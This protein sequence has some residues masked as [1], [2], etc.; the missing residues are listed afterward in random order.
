MY[1]AGNEKHTTKLG[2]NL[3][4]AHPGTTL[5]EALFSETGGFVCQVK[6][7]RVAEF[8]A[9][10][11]NHK[12]SAISLGEVLIDQDAFSINGLKL[13]VAELHDIHENGLRNKLK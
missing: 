10:A 7:D 12:A 5:A 13:D 2:A 8:E 11:A 6:A 9:L 4:F 1:F 3:E